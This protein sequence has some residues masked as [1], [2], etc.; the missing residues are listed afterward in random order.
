M[1]GEIGTH[2]MTLRP[3]IFTTVGHI[4]SGFKISRLIGMFKSQKKKK[5]VFFSPL[6]YNGKEIKKLVGSQNL[7]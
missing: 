5:N 2:N 7:P 4:V 1:S 3:V 6:L